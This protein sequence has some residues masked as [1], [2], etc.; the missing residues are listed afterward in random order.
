MES[1]FEKEKTIKNKNKN[2]INKPGQYLVQ[3]GARI[4]MKEWVQGS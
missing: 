3:T 1:M 2:K 4:W